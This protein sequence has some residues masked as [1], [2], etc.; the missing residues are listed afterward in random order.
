MR[1]CSPTVSLMSS[2]HH[3]PHWRRQVTQ[4]RAGGGGQQ[5][6]AQR[7]LCQRVLGTAAW[8]Q[9]LSRMAEAGTRLG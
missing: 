4:H 5:D 9:Q 1:A 2:A 3:Q 8:V 6:L 7:G